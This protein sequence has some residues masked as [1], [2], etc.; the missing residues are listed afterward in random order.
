MRARAG[1]YLCA[2]V[3]LSLS[4]CLCGCVWVG[5]LRMFSVGCLAV[6]QISI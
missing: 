1:V 6:G 4:L 3:S 2:Y 5:G